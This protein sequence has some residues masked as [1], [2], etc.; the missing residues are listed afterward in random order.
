[1]TKIASRGGGGSCLKIY[2]VVGFG[3]IIVILSNTASL[4]YRYMVSETRW[5][6][7]IFYHPLSL[8]TSRS[9][10]S[11]KLDEICP[12][13]DGVC[14]GGRPNRQGREGPSGDLVDHHWRKRPRSL[15]NVRLGE[16]RRR[17]ENGTRFEEIFGPLWAS[18]ECSVRAL[19]VQSTWASGRR[20]LRSVSH[21]LEE[22]RAD[23]CIQLDYTRWD[24]AW[25]L[26]VWDLEQQGARTPSTRN[27]SH[28]EEN[29]W[30]LPC[31]GM[32]EHTNECHESYGHSIRH[33][34]V[35]SC[36]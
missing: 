21:S 27:R 9:Q 8:G 13:L 22:A 4:T 1:M 28:I 18:E 29:R 32:H 30:N 10:C 5:L 3:F 36:S 16:W 23:L 24:T 11:G 20:K 25:Q 26:S 6:N 34:S 2:K 15:L 7:L 35:V 12:C 33:R 17:G 14:I 19:Q 31:C